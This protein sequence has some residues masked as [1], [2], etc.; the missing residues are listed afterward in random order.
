MRRT[1]IALL[2]VLALTA[3]CNSPAKNPASTPSEVTGVVV[4]IKSGNGF[5]DVISFTLKNGP[6]TYEIF[7]DPNTTDEAIMLS[8]HQ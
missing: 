5:G 8:S 6:D 3:C 2:V 7:T 4:S 1:S